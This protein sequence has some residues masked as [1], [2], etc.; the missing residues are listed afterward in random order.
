MISHISIRDFA[1]IEHIEIELHN[2]LN[3]ITGE[4]GSGKSIIIEAVSLAFGARADRTAVR[5]GRDKALIQVVIDEDSLPVEKRTGIELIS[6]EISASGKSIC[7]I[8]GEIVTLTGLT[9]AAAKL[10]DIHGQYDHQSLLNSDKHIDVIDDFRADI[11]APAA[12][13]VR[14]DYADYSTAKNS[15]SALLTEESVSRRELDFVKYEVGEIENAHLTIGEYADLKDRVAV[16]QN[17]EKIHSALIAAHEALSGEIGAVDRIAVAR[18]AIRDIAEYSASYAD[19]EKTL[20]DSYFELAD[21]AQRITAELDKT[22]FSQHEIDEAIARLDTIDRLISKYGT[23]S[24]AEAS[25]LAY[26]DTAREKLDSFE[27]IDARKAE[28]TTKLA[29]QTEAL[30]ASSRALS[31][32]RSE[33]AEAL[34][35]AVLEQLHELNFKDASFSADFEELPADDVSLT[36]RFSPSGA[37]RVEF[38]FT[39]NKGQPPRPLAKVAS[40]GEMSR[41]MLAIKT[42]TVGFDDI[43]TMIFDEIDTGISGVTASIVGEKLQHMSRARQIICITHLPQIA[44]CADHHYLIEK[45]SDDNATYTTITAVSGEERVAAIARLIGGKT[46]TPAT[47]ESARD[48]IDA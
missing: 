17:S 32:L 36:K 21:A 42:V 6:R 18:S 7:R 45:S 29:E 5:A 3:V 34:S 28:L 22:D 2:G 14:Q 19:T 20:S 46:I 37:D 11:V 40:G 4:T 26:L 41:V 24:G 30:T 33:A 25:V 9:A 39:A 23:V 13:R 47:L 12:E 31:K 38:L 10:A 16:M 35:A 43:P 15:L 8:N 27:N 48:L 1:I 44:A